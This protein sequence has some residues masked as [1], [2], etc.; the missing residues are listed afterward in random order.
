[1]ILCFYFGIFQE[2][3]KTVQD[4]EH[5]RK[6]KMSF[7]SSWSQSNWSNSF[8]GGNNY[9]HKDPEG[10]HCS[11][12]IACNSGWCGSN[13]MNS[14]YDENCSGCKHERAQYGWGH[15][16]GHGSNGAAIAGVL[17]LVGG[18]YVAKKSL[19]D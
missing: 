13:W 14:T 6:F 16:W 9:E 8:S 4:S 11:S 19:W 1:M 12:C 2:R 18:A 15:D 7:G 10:T 17:S 5:L 3:L